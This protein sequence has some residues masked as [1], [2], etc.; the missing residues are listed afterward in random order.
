MIKEI[1][2]YDT[3]ER[4]KRQKEETERKEKEENQFWLKIAS[5]V[6]TKPLYRID[7]DI[8]GVGISGFSEE[9]FDVYFSREPENT[10]AKKLS[11]EYHQKVKSDS[12]WVGNNSIEK[13]NSMVSKINTLSGYYPIITLFPNSHSIGVKYRE[14]YLD[15]K[16]MAEAVSHEGNY[17]V[18]LHTYFP[19]E[20]LDISPE[21]PFRKEKTSLLTKLFRKKYV[22]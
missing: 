4:E 3:I 16:K 22:R 5:E 1:H 7:P 8:R 2:H 17:E 10:F 15:A 18:T 6:L 14:A 11:D 21:Q 13:H 20:E 12:L 19:S 9:H